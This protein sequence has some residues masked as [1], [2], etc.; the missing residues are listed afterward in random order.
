M[1]TEH[2]LSTKGN[3]LLGKLRKMRTLSD[4]DDDVT[5]TGGQTRGEPAKQPAWMRTL[6]NNCQEWAS[7]LPSVS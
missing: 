5:Q 3:E 6:Y 7:I 4:D 2:D 1:I